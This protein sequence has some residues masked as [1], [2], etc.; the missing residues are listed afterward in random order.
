MVDLVRTS[1]KSVPTP[2]RTKHS[3]VRR[4]QAKPHKN[5]YVERSRTRSNFVALGATHDERRGRAAGGMARQLSAS[6]KAASKVPPSFRLGSTTLANEDVNDLA[7]SRVILSL[8]GLG[9]K[10]SD[11]LIDN[12]AVLSAR[13]H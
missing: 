1:G 12:T 11:S 2:V 8:S 6:F 10:G 7:E 4:P 13:L 3:H 5:A 9:Y